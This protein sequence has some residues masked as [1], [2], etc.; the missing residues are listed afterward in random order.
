MVGMFWCHWAPILPIDALL[1]MGY[2][3][4]R[5]EAQK[6]V[7]QGSIVSLI[8]MV[9]LTALVPLLRNV[10]MSSAVVSYLTL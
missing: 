4:R 7:K 5:Y 2:A 8:S 6:Y 1:A 3:T 9:L 10:L